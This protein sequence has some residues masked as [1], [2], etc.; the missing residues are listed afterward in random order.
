MTVTLNS[1]I[2]ISDVHPWFLAAIKREL[3]INNPDYAK[4]QAIGIST[5]GLEEKIQLYRWEHYGTKL[6]LPRGYLARFMQLLRDCPHACF[7][8]HQDN[9]VLHAP[10]SY[11]GYPDLRD[12]QKPAVKAAMENEQGCVIMPCGSGKTHCG[13]AIAAT[14]QQ[15]TLW[16]TH[17]LDLLQQAMTR[18]KETLGLTG[19]QLGVIQAETMQP[20]THMTFATVQTLFRRD[21]SELR[22]LFGCVIVDESHLCY[23]DAARARM[24]ESVISQLPARYRFGL[25]ASEHRADGLIE[26]MFHVIG[27]K[28]FEV[29]QEQMNAAGNVVVP[30]VRF[31]ETDF[32]YAPDEG[33]M[34]NLQKMLIALRGDYLRAVIEDEVIREAGAW[35]GTSV[36]VLGDSLEHLGRYHAALGD[37]SAFIHGGTPK[38]KREAL[39]QAVRD[40]KTQYLLATYQLAKLGLDLPRLNRLVLLTPKRDKT[41]IQQALG[42]T[43]RP[44]P[45]KTTPIVYD[46][47]DRQTRQLNYWARER[48]H[49][50]ADLGCQITGGPVIKSR[51]FY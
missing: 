41:S 5:W 44:F 7:L 28:I 30:Q 24:F 33:E 36:L 8:T 38:K 20:G 49:V 19:D 1:N 31:I 12:Y 43:M 6:I 40:G 22:D 47:W 2:E 50:Y 18:A 48:K 16:I 9:R 37:L 27:P 51:K 26:T 15:P 17:T 23:K 29:P 21:L 34:F 14:V 46:L 13:M 10:L 39:L 35:A 3:T 45:G 4:K 42:R 25:T 32:R 11:P